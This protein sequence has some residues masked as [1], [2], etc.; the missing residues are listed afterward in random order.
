MFTSIFVGMGRLW[1]WEVYT[2][3]KLFTVSWLEGSQTDWAFAKRIAA[4][5]FM[6]FVSMTKHF[7][8]LN[9]RMNECW[10]QYRRHIRRGWIGYI[11]E[12]NFLSSLEFPYCLNG[13]KWLIQFIMVYIWYYIKA[14][15][16]WYSKSKYIFPK[17][18]L[19]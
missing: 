14:S 8:C 3:S 9:Q 12:Y 11:K 7:K 17:N 4:L 10:C 13:F 16:F 2:E 5:A 6:I 19:M 15:Y 1:L 18:T